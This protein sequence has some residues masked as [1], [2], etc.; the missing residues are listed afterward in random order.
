MKDPYFANIGTVQIQRQAWRWR[1]RPVTNYDFSNF[2]GDEASGDVG[3]QADKTLAL[4]WE[5]EDFGGRRDDDHLVVRTTRA[6]LKEGDQSNLWASYN[7]GLL[8]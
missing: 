8:K 3:G 2:S 7:E 4:P 5:A 6:Q 1:G